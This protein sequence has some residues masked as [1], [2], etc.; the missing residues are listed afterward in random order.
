MDNGSAV[1]NHITW[2][3]K[4]VLFASDKTNSSEDSWA[5]IKLDTKLVWQE[6]AKGKANL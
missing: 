6:K 4:N 5:N 1:Q 3:L 2:L